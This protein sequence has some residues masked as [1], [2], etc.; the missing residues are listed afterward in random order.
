MKITA[1]MLAG[2][3]TARQGAL[4]ARTAA[5]DAERF[6]VGAVR[7]DKCEDASRQSGPDGG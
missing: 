3:Q 4:Q 2:L 7:P 5:S 6:H 1:E